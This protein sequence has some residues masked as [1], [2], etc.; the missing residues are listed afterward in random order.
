MRKNLRRKN[1]RRRLIKFLIRRRLI[2]KSFSLITYSWLSERALLPNIRSIT[3]RP[4]WSRKLK[5]NLKK[6]KRRKVQ[7]RPQRNRRRNLL[8]LKRAARRR[9]RTPSRR[10]TRW[11]SWE[12][13][14][15]VPARVIVFRWA[16]W[17]RKC[18]RNLWARQ[19]LAR[20]WEVGLGLKCDRRVACGK[21]MQAVT[22]PLMKAQTLSCRSWLV[23][24]SRPPR[25]RWVQLKWLSL[26]FRWRTML[27]RCL[28][29]M[30]LDKRTAMKK[31][32]ELWKDNEAWRKSLKQ[33]L[34]VTSPHWRRFLWGNW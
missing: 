19:D 21:E 32:E 2:M 6:L 18:I 12:R 25:S 8:R 11:C 28:S 22:W 23:G 4:N 34:P 15:E 10:I 27:S 30:F 17:A 14:L 33:G 1:Q 9:K 3:K 13:I 20:S 31:A 26:G 29:S 24:K 5:R 16:R 7:R